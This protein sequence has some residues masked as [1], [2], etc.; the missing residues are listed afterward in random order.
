MTLMQVNGAQVEIEVGMFTVP[1]FAYSA[2]ALAKS[3]MRPPPMP[4]TSSQPAAMH[5][6][7]YSRAAS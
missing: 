6:S 7:A 2:T 4:T 3:M 1:I 5:L